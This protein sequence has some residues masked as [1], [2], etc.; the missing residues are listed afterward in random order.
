MQ[1]TDDGAVVGNARLV[2]ASAA[3][4]ADSLRGGGARPAPPTLA[5]SIGGLA[6]TFTNALVHRAMHG[7]LA[8][9]L[10][11][12]TVVFAHLRLD[13]KRGMTASFGKDFSGT[14]SASRV[15][16]NR[17]LAHLGATNETVVLVE[18]GPRMTFAS[19]WSTNAV[20]ICGAAGVAGVTRL[21][22]SRRFLLRLD[23]RASA[24]VEPQ[25]EAA[26]CVVVSPVGE[27]RLKERDLDRAARHERGVR[28][29]ARSELGKLA[30]FRVVRVLGV[31]VPGREEGASPTSGESKA[32]SARSRTQKALSG[33]RLVLSRPRRRPRLRPP[34]S[35]GGGA[36]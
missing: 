34:R 11:M 33:C 19:A 36:R 26:R 8:L 25:Q 17:A 2:C 9:R 12:R 3:G 31:V 15:D 35:V 29:H 22:R 20:S 18:V 16:V 24:G 4:H 23:A 1:H 6:R 13:D 27:V 28:L 32:P 21:E 5:L 10:G 30:S 7:H 14:I